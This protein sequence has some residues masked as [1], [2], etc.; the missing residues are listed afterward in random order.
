MKFN[1]N[2][3]VKVRLTESGRRIHRA[4]WDQ[5]GIT[6]F[7]YQPPKEDS[8]G[9]SKWQ[10][11]CLMRDFGP[12]LNNGFDPPFKTEIDIPDVVGGSREP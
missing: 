5:L 3:E 9:W 2:N 10:L 7:P 8:R 12:H 6:S 4:Q 1:I 11:W